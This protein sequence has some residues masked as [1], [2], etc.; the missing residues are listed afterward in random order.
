MLEYDDIPELEATDP[1]DYGRFAQYEL[2]WNEPLITLDKPH[3]LLSEQMFAFAAANPFPCSILW[4]MNNEQA[5][6]LDEND[7]DYDDL[8]E[9]VPA[10]P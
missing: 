10:N 5:N 1:K 3:R 7:M 2:N 4:S 6:Q 9:L 8:P